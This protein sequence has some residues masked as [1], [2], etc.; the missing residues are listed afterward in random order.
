MKLKSIFILLSIIL[1]GLFL[2]TYLLN[3]VPTGLH[4]DEASQGYNA[5]SLIKT[6]KDMYGK[7][8]PVMFRANGSYQLPIYTYLTIIPVFLFGNTLLGVKFI[9]IISGVVLIYIT[10]LFFKMLSDKKEAIAEKIGLSAA[11]IVAISP[12]AVSFSRQ[13]LESNLVI[14]FYAAGVLLLGLSLKRKK[15][16]IAGCFILGLSTYVYY[17]EQIISILFIGIFLITFRKYFYKRVREVLGGLV[18]FVVLMLPHLYLFKTGALT[19]R[20]S[21][22]SYLSELN[23]Q[24]ESFLKKVEIVSG[25]FV[26]KYLDYF[27]PK[28]IF[29]NS[30][31]SL[32]KITDGL[33]VFYP[34]MLIPFLIGISILIK[35]NKKIL[36]R[37]ILINLIITPIPAALTGDKFY[38]YRVTSFLWFV[39]IIISLGIYFLWTQRSKYNLARLLMIGVIIYNLFY[40]YHQYF[41][42]SKYEIIGDNRYT[43]TKLIEKLSGY[44]DKN[45][46]IDNSG[47][48]WGIGI[49]TVYL[50]KINPDVIQNN[51]G[52]QLN[53]SYYYN[54]LDSNEIFKFDNI[55]VRPIVWEK[56]LCL[57][58]TIFVGDRYMADRSVV[59][60][61]G[62]EEIFAVDDNLGEPSIYGYV[63]K[64]ENCTDEK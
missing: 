23:R 10:F 6:G 40:L 37:L 24:N 1:L 51:L 38:L 17:S 3:D 25:S 7:Q 21:Q 58:N 55:T 33:S 44:K 30:D 36:S 31:S 43:Y 16:F 28:N 41:I 18:L 50:M 56:D 32:G 14:S 15:T 57:K 20:F 42:L 27:S 47:R 46:I 39:T 13:A 49:R 63:S 53:T 29:F 52:T 4:A 8:F 45:I 60:D 9:S 5:F 22:V 59:D 11:F 35:N 26:E 19:G 48:Y 34:W 2:R 64:N 62:L 54:K 61:M 12:W